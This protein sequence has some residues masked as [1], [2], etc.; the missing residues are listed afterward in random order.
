MRFASPHTILNQPEVALGLLPGG[1]GTQRLPRLV[2]RS[3]AL[4]AILGCDDID[5]DTA[6]RW[7]WV[8]RVLPE[9]RLAPFVTTL[10]ARI[11][12]FPQYAVAVA[13]AAAKAAVL[14]AEGDLLTGLIKEANVSNMLASRPTPG[15]PFGISSNWAVKRCKVKNIW[16]SWWR[17]S[18]SVFKSPPLPRNL[19]E[20]AERKFHCSESLAMSISQG[21]PNG[22]KINGH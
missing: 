15:P 3:R 7:G 8:N 10:A 2:G 21:N 17:W 11:A 16:A 5:A 22:Q 1:S 20:L 18:H 6:E 9:D 14:L 12:S 4:E 19:D 13:V